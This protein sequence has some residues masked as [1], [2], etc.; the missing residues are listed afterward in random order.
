MAHSAMH[1]G[2]GLAVGAASGLPFLKAALKEEVS[3]NSATWLAISYVLGAIAV[4]PSFLG[5]I[6]VPE[7]ITSSWYMNVFL[8]HPIIDRL[9]S[10]GKLIG[11]TLV[12]SCFLFQY[13]IM[14]VLLRRTATERNGKK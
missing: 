4:L 7:S 13:F 10:G 11:E 6:G 3:R 2:I 14:L 9:K 8:L 5:L 12:V 1:F